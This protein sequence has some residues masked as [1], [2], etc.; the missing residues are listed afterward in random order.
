[1]QP[2]RPASSKASGNEPKCQKKFKTL[3]E[4]VLLD[5]LQELKSYA[6]V[7]HHYGINESTL[8]YIK[9]NKAV[10]RIIVSVSFCVST[11]GNIIREKARKLYH[12]FA[13]GDHTEGTEE[14]QPGPS[15]APVPEDFQASKGWFDHFQKCFN[16][17]SVSLHGEAASA[18]KEAMEKY[19][20]TFRHI[21]EEKGYKAQQAF[22]VDETGLFWKKMLSRTYIMKDEAKAPGF[23][24]QKDRLV[25]I[26]CGNAADYMMKPGLIYK[27]ANPRALKKNNKKNLL[28][29][30]RM[31]SPKTWMTSFKL[32]SPVLYASSHGIPPQLRY[33]LQGVAQFE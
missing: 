26:M 20:E 8:H 28:P 25:L 7:A 29:V 11:I 22:N 31:H 10:I 16:I 18:D 17:K 21:I 27:A 13:T 24:A 5:L 30:Y 3:Q 15:T 9:K 6:A 23:K 1:M 14:P 33:G 2:K 32:V 4:K 12:Q 19:L